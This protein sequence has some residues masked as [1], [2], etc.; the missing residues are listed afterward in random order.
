MHTKKKDLSWTPVL[1]DNTYCS[2]ACGNG[3]TKSEYDLAVKG[4]KELKKCLVGSSWKIHVTENLGWFFYA[5]SGPLQVY[6]AD[7]KF[8]C[9]CSDEP[10]GNTGS[11]LWTIN[12]E[13]RFKDPNAAVRH[14]L[15]DVCRAIDKL[16]HVQGLA[17]KAAGL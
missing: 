15:A 8:F 7:G 17:Q 4:G 9:R 1:T 5:T 2:P 13:R 3:C 10:N 16:I 11:M 14:T 6:E 12:K